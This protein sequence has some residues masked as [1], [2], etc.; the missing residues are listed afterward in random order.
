MNEETPKWTY[1]VIVEETE[2]NLKKQERYSIREIYYDDD[3][4]PTHYSNAPVVLEFDTAMTLCI[5]MM[6]IHN[7]CEKT[8]INKFPAF[9]GGDRFP[10]KFNL[11]LTNS[12]KQTQWANFFK[13]Y[14]IEEQ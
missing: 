11:E 10:D 1:G 2:K 9:Y 5:S 6:K 7:T 8:A 13:N 3:G 12:K 4:N 14:K